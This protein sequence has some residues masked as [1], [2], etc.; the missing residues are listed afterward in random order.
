MSRRAEALCEEAK[1]LA[2][3]V[4]LLVRE[5]V[6]LREVGYRVRSGACRLRGEDIV[7]LDRTLAA[8][9]RLQVL[10]DALEGRDMETHFLTPALRGLLERQGRGVA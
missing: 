7:F 9:E 3:R 1:E 2:K 4:G 6:L 5:E 8:P 10:L